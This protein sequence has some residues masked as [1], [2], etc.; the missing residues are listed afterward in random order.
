MGFSCVGIA[1]LRHDTNLCR[2][3]FLGCNLGRSKYIFRVN[4]FFLKTFIPFFIEQYAAS[5]SS[6]LLKDSQSSWKH[7]VDSYL[8]FALVQFRVDKYPWLLTNSYRR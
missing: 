2:G 3:K 5:N 1:N 6:F 7:K 4:G 8:F